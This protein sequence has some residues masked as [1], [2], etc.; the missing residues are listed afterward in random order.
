MLIVIDGIDG[1]G[2]TTQTKLLTKHF[3]KK[4]FK[5]CSFDFPQYEQNFFGKMAGQYLHGHF[6]STKTISPYLSSVLYA[7]DRWETKEKIERKLKQG[8]IVVVNR[9]VPS[10]KIH[11]ASKLKTAC[12][13]NKYLKWLDKLEYEIFKIPKPDL[14]LFLHLPIDIVCDLINK[15][16]RQKDEHERDITHLKAALAIAKRLSKRYKHWQRIDCSDKGLILNKEQ[17]SDKL[18]RVIKRKLF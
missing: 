16:D 9:Y 5:A 8:C 11:Q 1:S 3:K 10:S 2:K 14:V 6:G 7:A 17:I 18:W 15:R 13:Q 4:G 12:A